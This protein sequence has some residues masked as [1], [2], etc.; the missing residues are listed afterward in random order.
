MPATGPC[1][2]ARTLVAVRAMVPVTQK[3]PKS[4]RADVGDALGDQLGVRAVPPAGHAVGDHRREQ[5]LDRAEQREAE[6]VG[7]HRDDL[8]EV[9]RGSAGAGKPAGMPPKALPIVATSS[10][11][12]QA[13]S[14]GER[15]PRSACA[16]S[17]AGSAAAPPAPR[18]T[19]SDSARVAGLSVGSACQSAGSF[20]Q[21]RPRLG[22]GE[23]EAEQ[24][25]ELAREDDR[26]DAGGEADRHRVGDELDEGAEP[27][28]ARPRPAARPRS[29]SRGS[30]RR[31]RAAATVAATS[32]MKAP[33]GPP[34]W[35]RLPPSA[36]TR[37]PPTIA[38]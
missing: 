32:T 29:S 36:E 24:R 7:Q 21:E 1:A 27:Q 17:A 5:R 12:A 35:N 18:S 13:A 34:I 25:H 28:Q 3:P 19:P 11:S 9:D 2:P 6:G 33:A 37:K 38:V 30:A 22:P 14:G 10:R 31:S 8:G 26:G 23:R 16:A 4:A 20:S 15:R